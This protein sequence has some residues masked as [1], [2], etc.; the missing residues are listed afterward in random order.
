[1]WLKE[2]NGILQSAIPYLS[3][4][5]QMG[6]KREPVP[7]FAAGSQAAEAYQALWDEVREEVLNKH[8]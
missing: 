4:V 6:I 3:V 2:F 1:M 8:R 5:E 7:A